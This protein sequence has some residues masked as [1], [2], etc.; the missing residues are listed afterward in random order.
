MEVGRRAAD[1]QYPHKHPG[2]Y[3][4]FRKPTLFYFLAHK[5]LYQKVK[6]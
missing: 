5:K 2:M 4:S 3:N 6:I 1:L